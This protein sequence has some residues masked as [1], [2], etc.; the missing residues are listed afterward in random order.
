M[1][2]VGKGIKIKDLNGNYF[3]EE[4]QTKDYL[5]PPIK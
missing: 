5:L 2:I 4:N 3:N 1:V